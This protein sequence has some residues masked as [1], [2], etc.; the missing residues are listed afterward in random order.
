MRRHID[1][2]ENANYDRGYVYSFHFHLIWCTKYRRELFVSEELVNEMKQLLI[3]V[4]EL[5]E[6]TIEEMEVMEDHVHLLVSFKP[7]LAPSNAVKALKGGT[8]RLFL[9]KHPEIGNDMFWGGHIWSPGYYMST[10]G[11]MSRD[12]V[13]QYI[14]NQYKK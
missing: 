6:I 7:K 2:I 11:N 9:A 10:L 4:A 1:K 13:I 5:N 14:Q 3:Y 12:T 8:G